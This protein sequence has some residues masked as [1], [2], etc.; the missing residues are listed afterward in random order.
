[1]SFQ[2][3]ERGSSSGDGTK[4]LPLARKLWEYISLKQGGNIAINNELKS[5]TCDEKS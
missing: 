5:V 3:E 2:D 1:M 4:P